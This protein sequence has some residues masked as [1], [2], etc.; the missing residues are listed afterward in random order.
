M[1][2]STAGDSINTGV[3]NDVAQPGRGLDTVSFGAG[4][5]TL[6]LEDLD[7]ANIVAANRVTVTGFQADGTVFNATTGT[8]DAVRFDNV[9]TQGDLSDGAVA[10]EFQSVTKPGNVT[11]AAGISIVELAWEFSPGVILGAGGANE[12]NGT[13]LLSALGAST[14]TTAGTI[15]TNANADDVIIIAY[16]SGNAYIYHANEGAD[17]DAGAVQAG[18]IALIATFSGGISV[19]GFDVTQFIN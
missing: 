11:V 16:Q 2:G 5:V 14:G 3:G 18:E 6:D 9:G 4:I 17:V 10:G 12:L 1:V 19:G 8:V 15:T 7:V 13:T